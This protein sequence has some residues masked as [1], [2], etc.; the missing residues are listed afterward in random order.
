MYGLQIQVSGFIA[1]HLAF[2]KG[3][4]FLINDFIYY[5]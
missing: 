3:P 1:F 5:K 2:L 4:L